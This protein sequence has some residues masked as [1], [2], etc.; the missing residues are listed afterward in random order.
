M[1]TQE[2]YIIEYIHIG[3]SLKVTAFDP[4]TF[5]EA[6]LIAPLNVSKEYAAQLAINK[7]EYI[8]IKSKNY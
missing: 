7:L 2:E 4:A 8:I 5:T 3:N 1:T 6:S